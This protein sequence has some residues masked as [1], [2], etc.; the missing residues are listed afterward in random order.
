MKKL[1]LLIAVIMS[2]SVI[3][4]SSNESQTAV[5]ETPI[6][7]AENEN[8]EIYKFLSIGQ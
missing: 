3:G 7:S 2:G 1:S 4:C 5:E 6:V 8:I